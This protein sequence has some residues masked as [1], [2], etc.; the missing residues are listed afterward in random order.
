[1]CVSALLVRSMFAQLR[2]C[3]QLWVFRFSESSAHF[4]AFRFR[5][6]LSVFRFLFAELIFT[7][8][9]IER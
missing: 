2:S 5:A 9:F 8:L 7:Q 4:N 3:A 1:V 6:H